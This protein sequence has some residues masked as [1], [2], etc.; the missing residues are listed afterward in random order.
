[1]YYFDTNACKLWRWHS[2]SSVKKAITSYLTNTM[3]FK[4]ETYTGATQT[5]LTHKGVINVM[6]QFCQY[7]YPITR[8]G[9][10]YF[11]N[12]YQ[13]GFRVTPHVPDGP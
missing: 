7:Q 12:Y 6:M 9:P 13:L 5:N 11:Y 1:M 10:N 3:Y 4:A 2:G 8:I